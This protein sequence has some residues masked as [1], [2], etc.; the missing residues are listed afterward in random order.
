MAEEFPASERLR[1]LLHHEPKSFRSIG[2]SA[3]V[4]EDELPLTITWSGRGALSLQ[5]QSPGELCRS[6]DQPYIGR[7]QYEWSPFQDR[8][9]KK[10]DAWRGRVSYG[11]LRAVF[12]ADGEQVPL[13]LDVYPSQVTEDRILAMK[14]HLSLVADELLLRSDTESTTSRVGIGG[15]PPKGG[16]SLQAQIFRFVEPIVPVLYAVGRKPRLSISKHKP[17][18]RRPSRLEVGENETINCEENVFVASAVASWVRQLSMCSARAR[19]QAAIRQT[20]IDRVLPDGVKEPGLA[21]RAAKTDIKELH[22][23]VAEADALSGKLRRAVPWYSEL[24]ADARDPGVSP[25]IMRD[26]RYYAIRRAWL[27]VRRERFSHPHVRDASL[28]NILASTLFERW[29]VVALL[30]LLRELDWI[31]CTGSFPSTG[32]DHVYDI[33]LRKGVPWVFRKSACTLRFYYEPEFHHVPVTGSMKEP[34]EVAIRKPQ[35]WQS[36]QGQFYSTNDYRTPDYA[37]VLE[38]DAGHRSLLVG[39]AIY[40]AVTHEYVDLFERNGQDWPEGLSG[41]FRLEG[42]FKKVRDDYSRYCFQ[43][44]EESGAIRACQH[45]GF[46]VFPGPQASVGWMS[47]L[48]HAVVALPL[49]PASVGCGTGVDEHDDVIQRLNS[50]LD[51]GI[52]AAVAPWRPTAEI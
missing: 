9:E 46:V 13:H 27:E 22:N 48:L 20:M 19:Q 16:R 47:K 3:R 38:T 7:V 32:I 26:M 14:L 39:D 5:P 35:L 6:E 43:L 44:S 10:K 21:K 40:Q 17:L 15:G 12:L 4:S 33:E 50:L 29:A 37:I 18:R 45:L 42:K 23:L 36:R 30:Q 28:E 31:P 24:A 41:K 8:T 49:M 52:R 11:Q 51:E 2:H 25:Y 1:L 34:F